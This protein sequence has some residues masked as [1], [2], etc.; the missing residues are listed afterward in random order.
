[1]C[2]MF[3]PMALVVYGWINHSHLPCYLR[4]QMGATM[5]SK[6]VNA[7]RRPWHQTS[8]LLCDG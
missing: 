5:A 4:P 2:C 1:M 6:Q 8:N 3:M 7:W